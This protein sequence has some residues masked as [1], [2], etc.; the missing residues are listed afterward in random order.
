[1]AGRRTNIAL[2]ILLPLAGATGVLAF[3]IGTAPGAVV[4]VAH[5]IVG[6][7]IVVLT[8]WKT[9]IVRRGLRRTRRG[10]LWSLVFLFIVFAAVVSGFTQSTGAARRVGPLNMMQIHV[11]SAVIALALGA[12][13]VRMRRVRPRAVDVDRRALLRS[14]GLVLVGGGAFALAEGVMKALSLT[15]ADR[16]FTGSHERGSYRPAAMPTTQWF[17]DRTQHVDLDSYRLIAGTRGYSVDDLSTFGDRLV[18][19]LDCTSGWFSTQEWT[20]VRLDRL[21]D[22]RDGNSILVR[23]RTGYSR[24]FPT[25]DA[26]HLLLATHVGGAPLSPRHGAPLRLVAPGRRGF[27]WVKWIDEVEVDSR[28]PWWQSPFPLT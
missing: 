5:G 1:M 10:R 14:G 4:V 20:G 15:G 2:L 22:A 21:I 12:A 11:G 7:A 26:G 19:T 27:W 25:S 3:G 6:I 13:H 24:R 17:D 9:V 8:P 28:P 23:S 16:R 18:A